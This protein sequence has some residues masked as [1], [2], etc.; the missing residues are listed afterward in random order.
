MTH[1][2]KLIFFY[3]GLG[4]LMT[5]ELDAV[6]NHEW[7]VLPL[8]SWLTDEVGFRVFIYAHIPLFAGMVALLASG[9]A[10]L[11]QRTMLV[12]AGFLSLHGCLHWAFSSHEHYEFAS[13]D[14]NILIYGG[15][16]FGTL[17]LALEFLTSKQSTDS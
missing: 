2:V 5:H 10:L 13:V 3:L 11:K 15:A 4:A 1:T 8:T 17:Y 6:A 16:V 14:S 12:I 9:N 7:R